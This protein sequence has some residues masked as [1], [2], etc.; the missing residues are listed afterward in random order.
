RRAL[1]R[2]LS[3]DGGVGVSIGMFD[4][5]E[6]H[7]VD[8][9]EG[10]HQTWSA[11]AEG[12]VRLEPHLSR[13]ARLVFGVGGGFLLREVPG[14]VGAGTPRRIGGGFLTGELALVITPF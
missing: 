3:F 9:V 12:R 8:G 2:G 14:E 7:G 4:F 10:Q 13:S 6:V 1:S 11:A 5:R